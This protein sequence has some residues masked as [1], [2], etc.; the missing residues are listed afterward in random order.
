MR[1][2]RHRHRTLSSTFL[3]LVVLA[4]S[5][6]GAAATAGSNAGTPDLSAVV[7]KVGV[8][9][10]VGDDVLLQ[11]AGLDKTPYHVTYVTLAT[12]GLQTQAANQGTIDVG[13]GSVIANVLFGASPVVSFASV[14]TLKINTN[15]QSTVVLKSSSVRQV[16]DLKGH[17]VAYPPNTTSQYFLLRQLADAGLTLKDVTPVP[18]DPA[19]AL[20]A[21]LS[22]S[23]D[24]YAGFGTTIDAA[25]SHGARVLAE[26]GPYL[27]G[28]VGALVGSFN[29]YAPDL[30]VPAKAAAIADFIARVQTALAW[31]RS[32]AEQWARIQSS[33]T[34]QPYDAVLSTFEK[35]ER[36]V[37]SWVGPVL[38]AAIANQ[39]DVADVFFQAGVLTKHVNARATYSTQLSSA[40]ASDEASLKSQHTTWFITPTWAT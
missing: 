24:A 34:K 28:K 5:A 40:I 35:G 7:L 2:N 10:A 32:H 27:V 29:A 8:Y 26:G 20:S 12:G 30:K 13:R 16:R 3:A 38:P 19:T 11:A 23:V 36:Q 17:K 1:S 21:L 33:A 31:T 4:L 6:C 15:T 9:P 25:L 37:P 22:G 39:Q 14:A 18:L